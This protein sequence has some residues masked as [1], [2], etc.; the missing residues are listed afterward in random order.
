MH[1]LEAFLKARALEFDELLEITNLKSEELNKQL[2]YQITKKRLTK[3]NNTYSLKHDFYVGKI[4][5]KEGF[6]F[7]LLDGDDLYLEDRDLSNGLD[8]D[9]VLVR[10][11]RFNKVIEILNRAT[12]EL[13]CS[14]K[15]VKTK[16]YLIPNKPFRLTIELKDPVDFIGG[17]VILVRLDEYYDTSVLGSVKKVL[18]FVTDPGIDILSLVYEAGF[19]YEFSQENLAYAESLDRTIN[20][21]SRYLPTDEYIVT[22][23]GSDAKDLDDAISLKMVDNYYHLAVHIA[24][25]SHYVEEGSIIDK[26]AYQKATSCYLAD[27][28][29]PMLPRRLSNDLCSLNVGTEKYALSVY[30]VLDLQGNIIS[31]DIK[32]TVINVNRR[33]SYQEVNLYLNGGTLND[34]NL[35][36]NI[37][38]M[39]ELSNLLEQT[40]YKR[41]ALV[42]ESPEYQYILDDNNDIIDVTLRE[43]GISEGIIE[44]FM[45]LTNE[46]VSTH[47][48]MLDLP[49]IYRVHDKPKEERIQL[50]YEQLKPLKI[51]VPIRKHF[52]P[53]GLQKLLESIKG[54][55]LEL[56]ISDLFLKSMSKAK[57]DRINIG[58]FGLA[59]Q[60]YSHFTSPIRRYPDLLLHRL[61]KA[62]LLHPAN[63]K[64][65][66]QF[67]ESIIPDIAIHASEMEKIS[68]DLEREVDKLK[69]A[70]FMNK[71]I[72]EIFT[73]TVS[74]MTRSGLFVR[75]EKGIEGM[76]HV[77]IMDDYYV[78][79]EKKMM[80][81]GERSKKTFRLGNKVKVQL[82]DVNVSLRQI[83]FKLIK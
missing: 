3:K 17:E 78:Y 24:D 52:S 77:K 18:G 55:P 5:L 2:E 44:S 28:V 48:T 63:L 14:V 82:M 71:H 35:E 31:H 80:L 69:V 68:D 65:Q 73:A 6:G 83:S 21:E 1:I 16:I 4:D 79:D 36:H 40:R 54:D 7:L 45:I 76:V 46:V 64:K 29:I 32:E 13:V 12:H 70:E 27:R 39:L 61:V 49:C 47:L 11:G 42:F 56:I 75:T 22:I 38:L 60:F 33:L 9:I 15:K 25:V 59:S 37:D 19:P 41:G 81:T 57:Y 8:K 43:V 34:S 67:Y 51:N 62:F 74:G 23:D 50:L 26:E 53:K 58:H 30:M 10:K 20:L 66:I 72:G